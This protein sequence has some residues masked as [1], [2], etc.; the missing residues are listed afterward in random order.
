M[1]AARDPLEVLKAHWGFTSFRPMQEEV[2]ASVL[3]GRDTL[4]LLPTGAGKS[5]CFQVPALATG[6]MCL[7]VSPLIALMKDQVRSLRDKGIAAVAV[8]SG[9]R[10]QE[11]DNALESCAAGKRS[12]LYVS[13]ERLGTDLL[14]ARL[15]R[16]PIGLLAVDEAHCISQWGYDFR[17]AYQKIGALRERIP[18]VPVLA[19]TASATARVADDIMRQLG[20]RDGRVL[21]TSFRRPELR[22]W[23]SRGE[24]KLGRLLRLVERSEGSGIVYVR[25]RKGTVRIARLLLQHGV[26]AAAYHAGM[27]MD[28]RDRVQQAWVAGEVRFVAATTA[29]GMGIDKADVRCVAHLEPPADLESY[30]QETGRAGR[31]GHRSDAVLFCDEGDARRLRDRVSSSFPPVAEVRRVYQA[32]AD[33]HRIALGAGQHETYALDLR[34]LADR[35]RVKPLTVAN[36]LKAL[37]LDGSLLLGEGAREP[38]RVLITAPHRTVYDLRVG[39]AR[40]GPLL[41]MLLRLH[42]GLFEEPVMIDEER[43]AMLLKWSTLKVAA[44]LRELERTG[45]LMYRPRHDGPT[46]TLLAPRR[47]AARL[48]LDREALAAREER[49]MARLDAMLRFIDPAVVCREQELLR[50]F[51]E[52]PGDRCGRC[53]A[54]CGRDR[55]TDV[56][57]PCVGLDAFNDAA[58][59]RERWELDERGGSRVAAGDLPSEA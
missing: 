56:M 58:I 51:G 15:P 42:G 50:Y 19:L 27:E 22:Y 31:D 46:I 35:A 54:C 52:E 29:F 40:L 53:D 17:P 11:I 45:A 37:E 1:R 26:S 8:T 18:R 9:M 39:D 57:T 49:A 25:E 59:A 38:S 4:A 5:L 55:R 47:D 24:D 20:F 34:D 28:E 10:P 48:M 3:A 36:A 43:L 23:V 30:Y 33:R 12:F 2:I 14:L 13:P 44:G 21:R 16:L 7:V 32:F 6:R 41:E